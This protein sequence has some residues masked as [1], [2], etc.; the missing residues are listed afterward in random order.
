MDYLQNRF[1]QTIAAPYSVR[2]RPGATVST[3]LFWDEVKDLKDPSLFNIRNIFKRLKEH[4]D[5]WKD[6]YNNDLN[7]EK[8]L[9]NVQDLY[10]EYMI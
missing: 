2:P 4:G 5:I 1:G 3:P 7:M 6:I 10:K 8:V 9:L